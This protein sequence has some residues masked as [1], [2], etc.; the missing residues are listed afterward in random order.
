MAK[1]TQ[2]TVLYFIDPADD[3]VVAV[4]CATAISGITAAR[5]QIETTCLEGQ[6]RTYEPGLPTPGQAS[7]GINADPSNASHVRLHELFVSGETFPFAVGWSDGNSVPTADSNGEFVLPTDRSWIEFDGYVADFPF[8]FA[9]NAV[10]ASTVSIQLA[11][12]P[13]LV[14]K[15]TT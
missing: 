3:S 5:D 2:G 13:V 14:P 12:F 11:D 8:D 10:V 4:Q 9:L 1:K 6:S 15:S 7:V